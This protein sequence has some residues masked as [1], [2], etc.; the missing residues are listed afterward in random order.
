MSFS[1]RLWAA[2]VAM[3]YFDTPQTRRANRAF[4]RAAMNVPLLS[5]EE[6]QGLAHRWR[7][8][9]DEAALHGLVT[10]H[11]RLVISAATRFR[12]YG[13]PAADLV[14]EGN[15]GLMKAAA[16][17]EPERNVRF[18]TYATWWIRSSIQEYVLRNWSI[19]RTGTTAAQKSLFFNLRRLR[20]RIE[21]ARSEEPLDAAGRDSI[22]RAL[23][24]LLRDVE[25]ME[26]RLQ[27]P[28]RSLNA[29]MSEETD[30]EWQDILLDQRPGPDEIVAAAHDSETRRGWI[31]AAVAE[32]TP[33]EQIIIR[34][35]RLAEE[36]RTLESLGR[37]LGISK[38]RVRQ[39]EQE[40]M[41]K[42]RQSILRHA[43]GGRELITG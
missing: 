27:G 38:E 23:R 39:V 32:L 26:Q 11:V 22:A 29:P 2:A 19:V 41:A 9:G 33:R 21:G 8:K 35:R 37:H 20:A 14:Q 4:I 30:G 24:V 7:D 3:S 42:L 17:F 12:N 1:G 13:L 6:E 28:D 10:P 18:S 43:G 16:R 15:V 5:R 34:E 36:S 31:A 25:A 40:A